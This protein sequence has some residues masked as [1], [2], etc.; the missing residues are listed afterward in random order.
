MCDNGTKNPAGKTYDD[1]TWSHCT[2]LLSLF[3]LV[4]LHYI[5]VAPPPTNPQL[6]T[7]LLIHGFPQTSYQYRFVITPLSK[8]GYHVIAPD[9][10]GAGA[11]SHPPT[12][13]SKSEL[14]TDLHTLLYKHA[15]VTGKVHVVGQDIGGMIAHAFAVRYP[16]DT[17][18][19]AIG[20]CPLPGTLPYENTKH[21]PLMFHFSFQ[22][23]PDL[24]EMLIQGNERIYLKHFFDRAAYNPNAIT[25][26]DLDVYA[27]DYSQPGAMRCGFELYRTFEEDAVHNME[28]VKTSGKSR[29]PA[30]ALVG[31]CSFSKDYGKGMLEEVYGSNVEWGRVKNSGHW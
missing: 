18:S 30:M 4:R 21:S 28:M 22:Q 29:V 3:P 8:A 5:S 25:K 26:E 2:A 24:P 9:Y 12:G 13:Y 19:V 16:R 11:S 1:S 6:G 23:V 31:D 7:V 10:R 20:E 17:A 14:A 15:K 27:D